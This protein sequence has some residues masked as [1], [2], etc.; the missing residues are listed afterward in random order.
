MGDSRRAKK[1]DKDLSPVVRPL[2]RTSKKRGGFMKFKAAYVPADESW[3]VF[4]KDQILKVGLSEQDAKNLSFLLNQGAWVVKDSETVRE[5]TKE[6]FNFE[7]VYKHYP[8]KLGKKQGIGK[9]GKTIKTKEK[10]ELLL[11]AV[12]NY[13]AYC[14]EHDTE[15]KYIKH[16][17]SWVSIWEKWIPIDTEVSSLPA[18]SFEEL[19]TRAQLPLE[20]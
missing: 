1:V 10:Y 14:K 3:L 13:A 18:E 6:V 11:E 16:F 8:R 15:E 9:L 4:G 12:Q 7:E 5:K 2:I 19:S 20:C 17:D